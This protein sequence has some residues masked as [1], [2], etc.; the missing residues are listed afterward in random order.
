MV[1][2]ATP[3]HHWS[4]GTTGTA[5]TRLANPEKPHSRFGTTV[6]GAE[7]FLLRAP[8]HDGLITGN[9]EF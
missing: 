6:L 7:V 4:E 8:K 3:L 2:P 5:C 9:K 1:H